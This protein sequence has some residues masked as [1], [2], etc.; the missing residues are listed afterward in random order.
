M[1]NAAMALV[2]MIEC[3]TTDFSTLVAVLIFPHYSEAKAQL[4][5]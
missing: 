3:L 4:K 1:N 5:Y 2:Q